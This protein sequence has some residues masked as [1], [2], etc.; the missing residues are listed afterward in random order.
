MVLDGCHKKNSISSDWKNQTNIK[1]S[2]RCKKL[3]S[4]WNTNSANRWITD[5]T[6]EFA[7]AR[8]LLQ[9]ARNR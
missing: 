9:L 2:L 3:F 8:I 4:R 6:E 7:A 5:Q 1:N